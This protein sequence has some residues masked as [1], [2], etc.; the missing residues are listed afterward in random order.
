MYE[1]RIEAY[2]LDAIHWETSKKKKGA[3]S[4]SDPATNVSD[5]TLSK[6]PLQGEWHDALS[7][8]F[9]KD[10]FIKLEKQIKE[11]INNGHE[12]FPPSNLVFNALNSTPLSKVKVVLLGQDPYHDNGQ[13]MG[14]SFSVPKGLQIPPSLKN[15]YT[16]LS[17]DIPGFKSPG[18][19]CLQ[20]W[21]ENGVLLLNATLTVRAHNANS[22]KQFGWQKFT[23]QVIKVISDKCSHV[24]F[25]LWG[26]FAQSKEKL[27]DLQKHTVLKDAHPSPL[28]FGKFKGCKCF[29]RANDALK[30]K[31][32]EEI[33]WKLE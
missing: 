13:A 26:N 25:M 4:A 8:E 14:L 3:S 7:Q 21:A 15:I 30:K 32:M 17:S 22:H 18:H 23:D 31:G 28:S 6:L 16:E 9:G 12:V 19:G 27:I 2:N 29:S 20:K 10:Y 33:D 5:W 11:E 1:I 24:V